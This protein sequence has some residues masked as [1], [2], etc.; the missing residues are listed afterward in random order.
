VPLLVVDG[1]GDGAS[2]VVGPCHAVH[3]AGQI[4]EPREAV[5]A[6]RLARRRAAPARRTMDE[7]ERVARRQLAQAVLELVDR[8]QMG[9][10][11]V[12]VGELGFRAHVEHEQIG[13]CS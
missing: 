13:V 1:G 12:A 3:P 7:H 8:D 9:L 2:R 5:L 6:E 11:D 10:G 4:E